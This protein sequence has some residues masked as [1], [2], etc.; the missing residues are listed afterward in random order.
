[1]LGTKYHLEISV[2]LL[3]MF[4]N[5]HT[6]FETKLSFEI[7]KSNKFPTAFKCLVVSILSISQAHLVGGVS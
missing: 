2:S 7:K 4:H 1:M 3:V 6:Q 5:F